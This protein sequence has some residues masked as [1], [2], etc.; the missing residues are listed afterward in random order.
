MLTN[1]KKIDIFTSAVLF[2][3]IF[4]LFFVRGSNSRLLLWTIIIFALLRLLIIIKRKLFWKIRN[5]LIFSGLFLI[6]TPLMFVAIF[7]YFIM[8]IILAQYSIT[9]LDNM[10]KDQLINM[11][12]QASKFVIIQDK[13]KMREEIELISSY[14]PPFAHI[15]FYKKENGEFRSFFT[16]PKN[17]D[18]EKV[19][20]RSYGGYFLINDSIYHGAIKQIGDYAVLFSSIINQKYL[21]EMSTISDFKIK[22]RNP[23]TRPSP[24]EIGNQPEL[25]LHD[26][27]APLILPWVF[28]YTYRDFNHPNLEKPLERKTNFWLLIDSEKVFQKIRRGNNDSIQ[29]FARKSINVLIVLFGTFIIISLII[30]IRM[31]RVVT[32]SINEITKGIQK[33]RKG[34]FSARIKIKSR[35][36]MFYLAESFNEMAS[37]INRLLIEEKEKQR[38]KEELRIARSIQLKL[39]QKESFSSTE[40]EI[41]A[42]NVPATEIAGDYFDYFYQEGKYLSALVADVSGKGASA[43]FYMAELKGILNYLQK[44]I[45]SPADMLAECHESLKKSFDKKT[46]ITINAVSFRIPEREFLLSR[47]GHTPAI[48]F[49]SEEELCEELYPDGMAIG[50]KNFDRKK[51]NEITRTYR[52][53]DILFLF[54]DGLS[55]IMNDDDELL[56][57]ENLKKIICE[58]HHLP[59]KEI[60]EKLFDFSIKFSG[61]QNNH[62]DLTFILIKVK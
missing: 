42:A 15:A 37:G 30:G 54:S 25:S 60:K 41:E 11:E 23:K 27:E 1:L 3:S 39:L 51:M 40:F 61:G 2:I 4:L 7:F 43:A 53:G 36:Q 19:M 32:K 59:V 12:N 29:S 48:F 13:D 20:I 18:E 58:N 10:M 52:Q 34:D 16:Y 35:D 49:N 26:D 56:G 17:W 46:F 6:A 14:N 45:K 55:E 28:E 31:I 5:R 57:V 50:L 44:T 24:R 9:I 38:L 33:I 47:A 22:Y 62:D 21:D 8:Y